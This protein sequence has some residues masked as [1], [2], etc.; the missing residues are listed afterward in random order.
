[1]TQRF[2]K[3]IYTNEYKKTLG[4]DFLS[5]KKFIK[6]INKEVEFMIW[7][8]AGQEYYDAITRRYYKGSCGAV[9]V[10]S[11]T[12]MDSFKAVRS[13]HEKIKAECEVIPIVLVM[14]KMDLIED[15]V[16]T[17]KEAVALA[18]ELKLNLFKAS[19]KDNLM[20]SEIFEYLA[21][22]FFNKGN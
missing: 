21:I 1:M 15:S 9:I 2:A 10:F 18:T 7:D 17:E 20:I 11:C 3:N 14:N 19:V 22:E 4:V 5:K 8:T 13:W 16:V 6:Q 12:N